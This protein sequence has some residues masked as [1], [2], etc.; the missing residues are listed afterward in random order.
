M[1]VVDLVHVHGQ[2]EWVRGLENWL[3]ARVGIVAIVQ[4]VKA[5]QGEKEV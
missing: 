3:K 4:E 2:D 5:V 1:V